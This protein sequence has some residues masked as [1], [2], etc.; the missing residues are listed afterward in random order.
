MIEWIL[1]FYMYICLSLLLFN[2]GM[3]LYSHLQNW[4]APRRRNRWLQEFAAIASLLE[5]SQPLPARHRK[6]L[7]SRLHH[8]EELLAYQSILR[9]SDSP[10]SGPLLQQYIHTYADV[11]EVLARWYTRRDPM[12]RALFAVTLAYL[13]DASIPNRNAL[14]ERL[15]AYLDRS[16]IYCREQ[17]LHA[18]YALGSATALEQAFTFFTQHEWFHNAKL[19]AD[20]LVYYQGDQAALV[21]Q[22]WQFRS[23]WL[24]SILVGIVQFASRLPDSFSVPFAEGLLRED[25]PQ[26]VDLALMRYF[27][28]HPHHEILPYLYQTLARSLP[29]Q[30]DPYTIVAAFVLRA[31]PSSQTRDALEQALHDPNWYVR[32]N[33]A[34]SLVSLGLSDETI[35]TLLAGPD[36]Y[37]REI[38]QYALHQKELP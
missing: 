37:A 7:L 32:K 38:L 10:L 18:L 24:D 9:S 12:R 2:A 35:Q 29:A 3:V 5:Q 31:Y 6:L 22:L 23:L 34:F 14:A 19:I 27:F 8:D 25:L 26:E 36:R 21:S 20:G 28:K 13:A 11:F 4:Y 16:T 33:A 17:V 30:S 1:Y 15:L